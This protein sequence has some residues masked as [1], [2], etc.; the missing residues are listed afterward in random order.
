MLNVINTGY[1]GI[2]PC[3]GSFEIFLALF[4]YTNPCRSEL[5][6]GGDPTMTPRPP[7]GTCQPASSLTIIA[8]RLAPTVG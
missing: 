3:D 2:T 5:A 6:P 8:S 7:R 1:T 4:P